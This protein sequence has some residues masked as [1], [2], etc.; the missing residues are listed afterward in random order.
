MSGRA[1]VNVSPMALLILMRHGQSMWNAANRFTGWV[2]VPLTNVGIEEAV[3]GGR[4]IA[5]LPID[6]VHVSTLV[7]AQM[8]AMLA[9]AQHDGGRIPVIQHPVPEGG[10]EGL[11][12]NE[13]RMAEWATIRGEA[14]REDVLPVHV[15]WQLNERMYGDLQGLDKQ[16]DREQ[17]GDEQV[18][19]WRRSY[20]VPP[21]EASPSSCALPGRCLP[22][23]TPSCRLEAG[24]TFVAAHG[25]SLRSVVMAIEGLSEDEVLSLEIPTGV[26]RVYA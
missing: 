26:P 22:R 23:R 20:D 7:R 3:A 6:E 5:H 2:D 24:R 14:G 9:L 16:D 19:I 17:Y 13:R 10:L 12:E 15:A 25:N 18:H 4:Q 1:M 21:P 8:T 11:G